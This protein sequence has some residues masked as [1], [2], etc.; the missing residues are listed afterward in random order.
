MHAPA[1]FLYCVVPTVFAANFITLRPATWDLIEENRLQCKHVKQ[2]IVHLID[3][4]RTTD[5]P[6]EYWALE[7]RFIDL[8]VLEDTLKKRQVKMIREVMNSRQDPTC[9]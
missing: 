6:D 2:A 9:D 1:V 4:Q 5:D 7:Q 8:I 3:T